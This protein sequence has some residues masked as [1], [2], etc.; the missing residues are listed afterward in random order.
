MAAKRVSKVLGNIETT[1]ALIAMSLVLG[2]V[3]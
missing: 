1:L 2:S 3:V